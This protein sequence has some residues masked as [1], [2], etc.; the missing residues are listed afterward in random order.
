MNNQRAFTLIE[1]LIVI[2]IIAVLA[3]TLFPV[4]AQAKRAAKATVC[5]SNNKQMAMAYQMYAG[6]FDD[7]TVPMYYVEGPTMNST[8]TTWSSR[9]V[10]PE[11]IEEP[12]GG[13]IYPYLK[14]TAV[15]DC[16]EANELRGFGPAYGMNLELT[17][18]IRVST[19]PRVVN[20]MGIPF[21]QMQEPAQTVVFGDNAML[22]DEDG[23]TVLYR[24]YW[25]LPSG[26]QEAPTHH[27]RH[28]NMMGNYSWADG[29]AR[30]YRLVRYTEAPWWAAEFN[31][32]LEDYNAANLGALNYKGL[33]VVMD[34]D[35]P[36]WEITAYYFMVTKPESAS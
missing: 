20:A 23:G 10:L 27:G 36:A 4:F 5:L 15:M 3:S 8:M 33:P 34:R 21:S 11:F 35:D 12:T 13:L 16:P 22:A 31:I 32:T 18:I 25:L 26:G 2:A 1:L 29:H 28:G 17:E 24:D 30:A 14:S 19:R 9:I 7:F 6:D